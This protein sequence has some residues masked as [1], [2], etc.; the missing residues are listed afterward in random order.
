MFFL[1]VLACALL[2]SFMTFVSHANAA[3]R[4]NDNDPREICVRVS[5]CINHSLNL[6]LEGQVAAADILNLDL[7]RQMALRREERG[8]TDYAREQISAAFEG[9]INRRFVSNRHRFAGATLI[10]RVIDVRR[11]T[12]IVSGTIVS[13]SGTYS[14]QTPMYFTGAN[15]CMFYDVTIEGVFRL[16]SWLRNHGSLQSLYEQHGVDLN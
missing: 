13:N 16:S 3:V 9:L 1:R 8:I 15:S 5:Q 11:Q 10:V 6:A 4:C 14:Y 7:L 2:M 12:H